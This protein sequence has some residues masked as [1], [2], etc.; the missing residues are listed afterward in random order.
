M[1]ALPQFEELATDGVVTLRAFREDDLRA[2]VEACRDPEVVR[3]TR[4]PDPYGESDAREFLA[5]TET[6]R[7][8]GTELGAAIADAESGEYLGSVAVRVDE[9]DG[10]R[11]DI[12]YL[13]APWARR[14]GVAVRAVRLLTD[15]AFRELGLG[16]IEIT[17]HPDNTASQRVAERAG[18]T[19]E[20]VLRSYITMRDGRHDAVM[21]SRLAEPAAG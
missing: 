1:P 9:R 2:I 6:S 12:G 8:R 4:V 21:F 18:Y 20:A 10:G 19:R 7:R 11:G 15:H 5:Q 17:V 14:R 13:V 16:R 3:W